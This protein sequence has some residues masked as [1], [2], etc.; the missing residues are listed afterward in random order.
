MTKSARTSRFIFDPETVI[1]NLRRNIVGQND[2][3]NA[4][5][6]ML[7]LLKADFIDSNRPLSINFFL[8]PTGVGKTETVKVIS[9]SL[10]G[11]EKYFCR[12]DMNT[13]A[14]EH[15]A[16][17]LTG[18]PP[19]YVGSKEGYTLFDIEAIEGSFSR[20]G[21][22]LF[23]EIEK[24]STEVIRSV[25]NIL[26]TGKLKLAGGTR[27][28]NF[29]N[30]LIFMTSNVGEFK[31]TQ[32][33]R[34]WR[35]WSFGRRWSS[36]LLAEEAIKQKFDPEFIGRID[37]IVQFKALDHEYIDRIINIELQKLT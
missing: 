23:D 27:E 30:C 16:A 33:G 22:V 8:G 12:I 21:I 10:L 34:K 37:R 5:G 2:V 4:M 1:E 15:Y 25:L 32:G 20:P 9:K 17:A 31:R 35:G 13:L 28:I 3:I 6:E 26:D 19:G 18:A 7:Y 29:S 14:Q 36:Q 11:D 24:A